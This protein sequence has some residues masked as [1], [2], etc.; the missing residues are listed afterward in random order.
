VDE[1]GAVPLFINLLEI[2]YERAGVMLSVCEDFCTIEG[3]DMVRDDLARRLLEVG[4]VDP[5]MGVEPVNLV[6]Y[7]LARYET[8]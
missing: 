1:R 4:V 5:K 3:D 6:G 2:D 8:L 7:K